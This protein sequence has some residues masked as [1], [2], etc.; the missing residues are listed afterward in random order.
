MPSLICD[1]RPSAAELQAEYRALRDAGEAV[2]LLWPNAAP[3]GSMTL[4]STEP[5]L[6]AALENEQLVC[7][8]D[9]FPAWLNLDNFQR[10]LLLQSDPAADTIWL[11]R[12]FAHGAE[13][14]ELLL[15]IA[16]ADLSQSWG[17]GRRTGGILYRRPA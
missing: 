3:A 17:S 6:D 1:P 13:E 7:I 4:V 15:P 8:G 10:V 9:P 14:I 11:A 12:L 16:V 5:S 2:V